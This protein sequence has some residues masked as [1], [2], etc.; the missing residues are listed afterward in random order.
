MGHRWQFVETDWKW[1]D[2][3][4]AR[5]GNGWEIISTKTHV[6]WCISDRNS[7]QLT[8]GRLLGLC[9][10][11]VLWPVIKA[12]ISYC[13]PTMRQQLADNWSTL[14]QPFCASCNTHYIQGDSKKK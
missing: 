5:L 9:W 14:A 3:E 1:L 2:W 11:I 7:E 6:I 10:Q 13:G 12:D 4:M 8:I